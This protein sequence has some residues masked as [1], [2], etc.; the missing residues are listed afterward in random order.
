MDNQSNSSNNKSKKGQA[1]ILVLILVLPVLFY[2]FLQIFGKNEF[3]ELDVLN[4]SVE[5]CQP[6]LG[7][8]VHL[9][10]S[11]SFTNQSGNQ[12]S[13]ETVSGKIYVAG[14]FDLQNADTARKIMT[15]FERVQERFKS[16]K[17]LKLLLHT[18]NPKSDS[19]E[20]LQQYANQYKANP[21]QWFFLTGDSTSLNNQLRCGYL[22][23]STYE[24]KERVYTF[25]ADDFQP[26]L[27]ILIDRDKQIRGYFD[28]LI[29]TEVDRMMSE[30]DLLMLEYAK[31]EE[32]KL[33]IQ[34]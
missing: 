19:L 28:A 10:P 25:S 7:D 9:I 34:G 27:F 15:A 30:I 16:D 13:D 3:V 31:R 6:N 20:V 12:I 1:I 24:D 4:P 29:R 26:H 33:K 14:F 32:V 18:F 22:P 5:G 17:E 23:F 2:A 21:E 11:F 8:S